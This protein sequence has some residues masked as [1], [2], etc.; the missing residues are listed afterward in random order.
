L[1]LAFG[2]EGCTGGAKFELPKSLLPA[3]PDGKA[4]ALVMAGRPVARVGADEPRYAVLSAAQPHITKTAKSNERAMPFTYQASTLTVL[5]H[6]TANEATRMPWPVRSRVFA[7]GLRMT[8]TGTS[9][10]SESRSRLL[11]DLAVVALLL[12]VKAHAFD[13]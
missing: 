8:L 3:A 1:D 9:L 7:L 13:G 10:V 4:A 12:M 5:D 6:D 2:T 11:E